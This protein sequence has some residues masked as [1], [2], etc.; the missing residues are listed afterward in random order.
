MKHPAYLLAILLAAATCAVTAPH[1]FAADGDPA[2]PPPKKEKGDGVSA[3]DLIPDG[4]V[5]ERDGSSSQASTAAVAKKLEKQDSARD[6]SMYDRLRVLADNIT[7]REFP[8][9]AVH[10]A[11]PYVILALFFIF[12]GYKVYKISVVLF[13]GSVFG[14]IGAFIAP[15]ESAMLYWAIGAVIGAIVA[16]PLEK[17][18][19]TFIGAVAGAVIG[20]LVSNLLRTDIQGM[21]TAG[22]IGF[23]AGGA[24][25][26]LYEKAVLI[27]RHADRR[28]HWHQFSG[29]A[30]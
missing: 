9:M 11:V 26:F 1:A 29:A 10:R 27:D 25:S 8:A 2:P 16:L 18:I 7:Q 4:I 12:F 17:M 6:L 3:T 20:V 14:Q 19:F 24:I 28:G 13:L 5:P 23:L 21:L 15:V 30:R 22:T